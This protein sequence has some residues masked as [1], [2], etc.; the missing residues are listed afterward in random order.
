MQLTCA[1][2]AT[3]DLSGAGDVIVRVEQELAASIKG[4]GSVKYF[5]SPRVE[6]SISGA[7]SVK[8]AE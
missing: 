8:P 7:G 5:G 1:K 6:Q 2:K 4:A 3:V